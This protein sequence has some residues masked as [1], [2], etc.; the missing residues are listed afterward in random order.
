MDY[1]IATIRPWNIA[2]FHRFYGHDRRMHLITDKASLTLEY[3][4]AIKPR[5]VFFP[6]WSW[7]IPSPIWS[8]FE[9][10]VFHMTDLPYGRGGSPLQNLIVRGHAQTKM[11]AL[12]VEGGLDTGPIYLKQ[13]LSLHGTAKEI[14]ERASDLVFGQ[15]IPYLVSVQPAP[16]PQSGEVVVFQ[17]RTPAQSAVPLGLSALAFYDHVRMLDAPEYPPAFIE[18]N[19]L[20]FEFT[21]ASLSEDEQHVAARVSVWALD[22]SSLFSPQG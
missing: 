2:A 4:R 14:Y 15:M 21:E 20:K 22:P 13:P 9:C 10:V 18:R 8:E 16:V 5:Y 12:R 19:G 11:S 17:R 3:L 6:H 7:I 1:V